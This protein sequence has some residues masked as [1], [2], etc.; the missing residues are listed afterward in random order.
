MN[1]PFKTWLSFGLFSLL[2]VLQYQNCSNYADQSLFEM[3]STNLASSSGPSEIRLDSPSGVID[4][5]QYEYAV[6]MGGDCNTGLTK[7]H[8]I[9]IRLQDQANQAVPVRVA[10]QDN[11]CPES[12]ANLPAHCFVAQH[13]KCEHGK[14]Y[15]H[16]PVN[17][18]A[19]RGQS[20]SLYRIIGQ[21]VTVD[22]KGAETRDVKASF[23]RFF[24]IA[25]A[26]NA[27]P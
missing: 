2:M 6:S 4:V 22:D 26:N 14:Y 20:S 8:Y 7:K 5:G 11:T 23:N 17:C 16:V 18:S 27:C 24:Q 15:V 9:E 19:Y 21:M 1:I 10:P 3:A 25:W 13:F 12:G